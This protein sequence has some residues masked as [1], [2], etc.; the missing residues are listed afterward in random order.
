MKLA[1]LQ[2]KYVREF[3]EISEEFST[4]FPDNMALSRVEFDP[5]FSKLFESI[6]LRHQLVRNAE[7]L[8]KSG[9][10]PFASFAALVGRSILEIWSEYVM[11]P[12]ARIR[13]A[14]GNEQEADAS[15]KAL[16]DCNDIVLDLMA[17]LTVHKLGLADWL[18]REFD[19]VRI[20]QLVYDE[21]QEVVYAMRMDATPA[22]VMGKDEEGNYTRMEFDQQFV[23]ERRRNL[24]SILSLADSLDRI[25]SYPMLAV[26]EAQDYIDVLT[27]GG[28]GSVFAGEDDN[29]TRPVLV[30]DGPCAGG[31]GALAWHESREQSSS[32][33]FSCASASESISDGAYYGM[34]N[35]MVKLNYW[36]VRVRG[37]G[38]LQQSLEDSAYSVTESTL[39][40]L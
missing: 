1:G 14:Y 11:D 4:R 39:A 31:C 20:P 35:E 12:V 37:D 17:L 25:P 9:Q 38:Y 29:G 19:R 3:Q 16:G 33:W 8:Y 22:A 30:S 13:F 18:R 6:D 15:R 26:K 7:E 40:M 24:E 5:Q 10:I 27:S 36:F 32:F 34:I 28:A 2:S 23:A 21:I